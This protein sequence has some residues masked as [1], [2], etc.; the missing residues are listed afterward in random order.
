MK[1]FFSFILNINNKIFDSFTKCI[2]TSFLMAIGVESERDL[3]SSFSVLD[4]PIDLITRS[5][6]ANG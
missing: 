6:R 5:R 4:M 1:S 3:K 2:Y